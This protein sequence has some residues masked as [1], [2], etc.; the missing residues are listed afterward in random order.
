MGKS[1]LNTKHR[2][3]ARTSRTVCTSPFAAARAN[4]ERDVASAVAAASVRTRLGCNTQKC[5]ENRRG[6][7]AHGST[8][9]LAGGLTP[10]GGKALRNKRRKTKQ[11]ANPTPICPGR[12]EET[13]V[14]TR[15]PHHNGYLCCMRAAGRC[16]TGP[17]V[18]AP[19]PL[20]FT[21][22][23]A[24]LVRLR[25]ACVHA[26]R[27]VGWGGGAFFFSVFSHDAGVVHL[28]L[29]AALQHGWLR[30]VRQRGSPRQS[31][32]RRAFARYSLCACVGDTVCC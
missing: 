22:P 16:C 13:I 4:S 25:H 9:D 21:Y 11:V 29:L 12:Y 31:D 6:G 10:N 5:H 2:S 27:C 24:S 7:Q 17:P 30:S 15:V 1:K 28:A 20:R 19:V 23:T 14:L 18:R 32:R 8:H 3:H 26:G